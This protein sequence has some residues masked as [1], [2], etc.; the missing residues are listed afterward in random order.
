MSTLIQIPRTCGCRPTGL[1]DMRTRKGNY[2]PIRG[3]YEIA[4]RFHGS[5]A[6]GDSILGGPDP[7]ERWPPTRKTDQVKLVRRLVRILL[8]MVV[9]D[10]TIR[11][12]T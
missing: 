10:V 9:G 5:R 3:S 4:R 2:R 12:E 7:E 6:W 11:E 1:T 8:A